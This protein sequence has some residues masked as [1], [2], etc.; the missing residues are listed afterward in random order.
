[1]KQPTNRRKNLRILLIAVILIIA[2]RET[3]I[4]NFSYYNSNF[5][6]TLTSSWQNKEISGPFGYENDKTAKEKEFLNNKCGHIV[7]PGDISVVAAY[8]DEKYTIEGNSCDTITVLLS[9]FN[10]GILWTPLIKST[11]FE[12]TANIVA[13]YAIHKAY[14][15]TVHSKYHTLGGQISINGRLSI[16]GTCSYKE[17]RRMVLNGVLKQ[18]AEKVMEELQKLNNTELAV[19]SF[20]K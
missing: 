7:M 13:D 11:S 12:A 6:S 2:L 9:T 4:I 20:L 19:T 18:V 1:V 14:G 3:G 16:I 8:E 15:S 17:A 10:P 5:N